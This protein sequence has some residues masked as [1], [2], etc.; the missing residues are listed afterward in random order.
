MTIV[1]LTEF[2]PW[3][4]L[5]HLIRALITFNITHSILK[6]KYN[7]P[8]TF[9]SITI[10]GMLYSYISM[11]IT[12]R[13]NE[14]LIMAGY[15]LIMFV[16]I[17]FTTKGNIF[18]K[19]SVTV[20][21]L[22]AYLLST[23]FFSIFISLFSDYS[24][25]VGI[26]YEVPLTV[27]LAD[28]LSVYSF[29]FIFVAL[30]KIIKSKTNKSFKYK[31]KYIFFF[32]F[33]IT[34][35]FS[36]MQIFSSFINMSDNHNDNFISNEHIEIINVLFIMLCLLLDFSIIFVIDHF[37][38]IEEENIQHERELIKK[39]LDYHQM[40][41]LKQEKQEF[42]KIK[43]DFA[44]IVTTAQGFIE[45]G[46]SE[47]ALSILSNT[48]EDLL[49]L[50]GFSICSNETINTIIYIKQQ[51][52]DRNNI[53]L[54]TE[55]IEKYSVQIEDYDLCRILHNII[56]NSLNAASVLTDD[57]YSKINIEINETQII[58]K[59]ENKYLTAVKRHK[60][61]DHGNGI[62]I[63]KNI[64]SKYGGKYVCKQFN[65]IWYTETCLSNKKP[66]N[67][68]PPPEFWLE[69]KFLKMNFFQK[70]TEIAI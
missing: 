13:N 70:G 23:L 4:F 9:L 59:S 41:M 16:I 68:T 50:T 22:I 27:F 63:I 26:D 48:N 15:Y 36:V 12:T 44:N 43:H 31:T 5:L 21:S 40:L 49:S 18:S 20:F 35:I 17:F 42:T 3:T 62:N 10:I 1:K 6:N 29:S 19:I 51:Q 28:V 66:V 58:I 67:S 7:S 24:L 46:K 11:Y 55:I 32:L 65:D 39:S 57:R 2:F 45:I 54:K 34:H 38:K 37:E 53:K 61:Q 60:S 33:P 47:K 30:I 14:L 56:D 69:S 25:T 8:V 64:S 52:A